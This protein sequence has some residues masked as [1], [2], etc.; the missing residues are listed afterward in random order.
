MLCKSSKSLK[1]S[2]LLIVFL[3]AG[4]ADMTFISR[5][6]RYVNS[7]AEVARLENAAGLW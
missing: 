6:F 1:Y 4:K 7:E 2:Q 5:Q 3:N